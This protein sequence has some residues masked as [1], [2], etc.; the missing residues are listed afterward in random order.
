M[1]QI[2]ENRVSC[3]DCTN[4]EEKSLI[5]ALTGVQ[6]TDLCCK[7]AFRRRSVVGNEVYLCSKERDMEDPELSTHNH[8]LISW[9]LRN[10]GIQQNAA[11]TGIIHDHCGKA[12]HWFKQK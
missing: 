2:P 3:K 9:I 1:S 6:F 10:V 4:S 12:G 8:D 11:P 7:E 5:R